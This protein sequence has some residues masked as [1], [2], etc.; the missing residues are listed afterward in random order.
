MA[1]I[2]V[3]KKTKGSDKI[4]IIDNDELV[5]KV[6]ADILQRGIDGFIQKPFL[7][8]QLSSKIFELLEK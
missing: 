4:I 3:N 7:M 6:A 5:L 1:P 8:K 2:P